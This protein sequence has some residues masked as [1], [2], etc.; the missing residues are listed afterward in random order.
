MSGNNQIQTINTSLSM[1]NFAFI[2]PIVQFESPSVDIKKIVD[3]VYDFWDKNIDNTTM[4][5]GYQLR[6]VN[7]ENGK[8]NELFVPEINA[9]L[10]EGITTGVENYI[11]TLNIEQKEEFSTKIWITNVWI[12]I[13]TPG[14]YHR[15]HIH[16]NSHLNGIF[17]LQV[18]ENSGETFVVNPYPTGVESILKTPN[19]SIS[20]SARRG[21]G[22][23]FSSSLPHYT[24]P[25]HSE[26]DRISLAFEIKLDT[27][28]K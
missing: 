28:L 5:G 3:R 15:T 24:D 2:Q 17:Y 9:L 14:S 16:G 12:N 23:I 8:V 6:L 18:P 7:H 26:S 13:A 4:Q 25:N 11:A 22:Y 10:Q 20:L 27:I 19:S 21:V 1:S